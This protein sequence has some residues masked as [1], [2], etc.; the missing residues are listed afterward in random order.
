PIRVVCWNT[1]SYAHSAGVSKLLRVK[2][3]AGQH[4]SLSVIR[5]TIDLIDQQFVASADQ[6]RKLMS[7]GLSLAELRRYV[8][9][10]CDV[11]PDTPEKALSGR[12]RNRLDEIVK[13]AIS[14]KGQTGEL[15]AWAAYSG[16]TEYVTHFAGKDAEKRLLSNMSGTYG[17]LNRRAFDVAM[18]LSA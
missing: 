11:D 2:H 8:K 16:V 1:L 14:G 4:Q 6:Y 18:Q 17:N 5:D 15:T 12:M 13:L 9:I 3:T 10:V 7:C